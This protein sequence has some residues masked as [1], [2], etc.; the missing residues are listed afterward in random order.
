MEPPAVALASPIFIRGIGPLPTLMKNANKPWT[1]LTAALDL[2]GQL[3]V[4]EY[5]GAAGALSLLPTAGALPG[6]LTRQM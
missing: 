5:N 4:A 3:N 1:N 2:V 6:F